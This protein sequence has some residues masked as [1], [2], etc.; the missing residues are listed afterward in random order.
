MPTP[1]VRS[2]MRKNL[3]CGTGRPR[4]AAFQRTL[5]SRERA[6]KSACATEDGVRT[7]IDGRAEGDG[8]FPRAF[9]V[10]DPGANPER[11]PRL[12][13]VGVHEDHIPGNH[14]PHVTCR[15][16]RDLGRRRA[17]P[18]LVH[19]ELRERPP[20]GALFD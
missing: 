2:L 3:E 5:G 11:V 7:Y 14:R 12:R 8:I 15:E 4:G 1:I 10:T 6:V 17:I 18:E 13:A 19:A 9:A 20:P 16:E